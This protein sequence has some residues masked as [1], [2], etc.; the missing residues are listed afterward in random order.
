VKAINLIIL[1]TLFISC[2]NDKT[3]T[4]GYQLMANPWKY[5]IAKG[6]LN[7]LEGKKVVFKKFSSGAKVINAMASGDIDIA[8]AG[9][10]PIAAGLSQGLDIKVIWMMEIIGD[11]EAFVVKENI[12]SIKDLIGKKVAVP[13]GSTTH[14]HLMLALKNAGISPRDLS[15]LNLTPP[16]IVASWKKGEIDGAFVWAPALEDIKKSGKVLMSSKDLAN[17]GDP[18]FDGIIA[19]DEFLKKNKKFTVAFMKEINKLHTSYNSSKWASDS[20]E[21]STIAKF[22]GAKTSDVVAALK[23]YTFPTKEAQSMKMLSETLKKTAIF[24]KEQ[25]KIES[26]LTSYDDKVASDIVDSL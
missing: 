21:V 7:A 5:L 6:K 16:S 14:F 12:N 15:I 4:V 3:V 2:S 1:L 23:G 18:T 10:T 25:G 9:S 20:D 24:L 19:R 8:I 11:A 17:K 26:V 22:I 13:F